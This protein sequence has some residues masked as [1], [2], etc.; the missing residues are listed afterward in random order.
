MI[1]T[2]INAACP[3][4]TVALRA[5][6]HGLSRAV[7]ASVCLGTLHPATGAAQNAASHRQVAAAT[8]E[9][10]KTG[11]ARVIRD[12][13]NVT[14]P[15]DH[16]QPTLVC[17]PLRAC[18]L[19]L[20]AGETVYEPLVGDPSRWLFRLSAAGPNRNIPLI[21]IKPTDCD[22]T[23]NLTVPTDRH[24]YEL[25]LDAPPCPPGRTNAPDD[26]YTRLLRFYYPDDAAPW[27]VPHDSVRTDS[28]AQPVASPSLALTSMAPE[29]LNFAYWWSADKRVPWTPS[30]VFDDGRHLYIKFPPSARTASA[31]VLFVLEPDGTTSLL[32]YTVVGD[33][34]IT[35]RVVP[36]LALV[37]GVSGR[38]QR[39]VIESLRRHE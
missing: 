23:T 26:R 9:Y 6:V 32:N 8:Q 16:G 2:A 35:D 21:S 24:I 22:V 33:C 25:T 3:R 31:P 18:I 14:F 28:S 1:N 4:R 7:L 10:Q 17:A 11:V 27:P 15:Y 38:Q 37:I 12:G 13:D 30:H 34:Y 5:L 20:Q 39:V 19:E 29:Q 36:R